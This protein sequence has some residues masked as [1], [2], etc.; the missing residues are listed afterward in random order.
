MSLPAQCY[1]VY[2]ITLELMES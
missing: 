2:N 1:K